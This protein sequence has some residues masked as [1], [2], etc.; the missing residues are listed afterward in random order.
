MALVMEAGKHGYTD[1]QLREML[2]QETAQPVADLDTDQ[3]QA[4]L[5]ALR[6]TPVTA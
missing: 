6:Q 2:E 5:D 4:A 3:L 1:S